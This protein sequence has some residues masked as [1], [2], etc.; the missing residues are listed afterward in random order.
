MPD[1]ERG[2]RSNEPTMPAEENQKPEH[3]REMVPTGEQVLHPER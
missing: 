1:G 3:E 2:D